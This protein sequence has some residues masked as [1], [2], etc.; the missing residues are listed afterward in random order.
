MALTQVS[1]RTRDVEAIDA[2]ACRRGL[3]LIYDARARSAS[4]LSAAPYSGGDLAR[5]A[6]RNEAGPLWRGRCGGL[7][8]MADAET[9]TLLTRF[10]KNSYTAM[11]INAVLSANRLDGAA[12]NRLS[13]LHIEGSRQSRWAC[14]GYRA[15]ERGLGT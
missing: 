14:C 10:G 7:P 8:S 1:L 9:I 13:S 12:S 15:S 4:P 5:S 6:R 2:M 3:K 11:A